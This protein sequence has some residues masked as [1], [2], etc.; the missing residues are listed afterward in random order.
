[1]EQDDIKDIMNSL[2]EIKGFL[3]VQEKA[4]TRITLALVGLI[5]A[6][7]GVKVL[8]TPI[9]LDIATALAI[10]GVVLMV[11]VL[12]L[13]WRLKKAKMLLTK[14]GYALGIAMTFITLTQI[15]VYF[16]DL[17][18]IMTP[19]VVYFVRIL[20]NLSIIFFVWQL[21]TDPHIYH[22]IEKEG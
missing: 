1:M 4:N 11:G 17:G 10:I 9:L 16:R 8:G 12:I 15:W 20:Q 13:G 21:F 2:G 3:A 18:F 14:T 5:A 7:I 6:Q 22:D 19:D